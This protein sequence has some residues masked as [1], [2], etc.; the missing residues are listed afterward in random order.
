MRKAPSV[1]YPVGPCLL[2]AASLLLVG[3][4]SLALLLAWCWPLLA[5]SPVAHSTDAS[6]TAWL[7][8]MLGGVLWL[9]W[10]ALALLHWRQ[11][12]TG[13][14][15][16][17]ALGA[18]PG[19]LGVPGVWRWQGSGISEA[20]SLLQVQLVL[21]GQ[22]CMLLR[23]HSEPPLPRWIWVERSRAPERWLDMRRAL[24][25]TRA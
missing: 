8:G 13:A 15:Q 9:C 3:V 20:A 19:L 12:P 7:A 4:L 11:A 10:A 18:P 24:A 1:V 22:V 2:Y 23:L 17:D 5:H 25:S 16:W 21:D 14:L 6:R